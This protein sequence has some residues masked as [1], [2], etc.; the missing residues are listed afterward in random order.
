MA[1]NYMTGTV[2]LLK[3]AIVYSNAITTVSPTY[4]IEARSPEVPD[5][6]LP[7]WNTYSSKG[8]GFENPNTDAQH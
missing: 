5:P 6:G 7:V 4:A 2:N 1:D 8:L 3:G